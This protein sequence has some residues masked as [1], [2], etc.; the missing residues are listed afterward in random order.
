V[1]RA[2][3]RWIGN[4]LSVALSV[5]TDECMLDLCWIKLL[6][7]WLTSFY[8]V[9]MLKTLYLSEHQKTEMQQIKKIPVDYNIINLNLPEWAVSFFKTV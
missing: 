9:H 5:E 1:S 3:N 2:L 6:V 8:T 7:W 4:G